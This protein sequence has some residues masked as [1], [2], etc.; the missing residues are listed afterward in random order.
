MTRANSDSLSAL[1]A[2]KEDEADGSSSAPVGSGSMARMSS[3]RRKT[4]VRRAIAS[5][6]DAPLFVILDFR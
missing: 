6:A 1:E 4:I 3:L 2:F 5:M